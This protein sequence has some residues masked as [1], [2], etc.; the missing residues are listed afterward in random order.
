MNER[1]KKLAVKT[2]CNCYKLLLLHNSSNVPQSFTRN[3]SLAKGGGQGK[4]TIRCCV[5]KTAMREK[6]PYSPADFIG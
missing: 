6:Y 4:R 1:L 2:T 3:S 5:W